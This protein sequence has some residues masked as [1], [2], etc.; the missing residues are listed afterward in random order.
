MSISL[1]DL[2]VSNGLAANVGRSIHLQVLEVAFRFFKR[3]PSALF[4]VPQSSQA[5]LHT[6]AQSQHHSWDS[7]DESCGGGG[8]GRDESILRQEG[9]VVG[10]DASMTSA[11][12]QRYRKERD[13]R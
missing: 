12:F 7:G 8:R 11:K 1:S 5:K 4:Q 6:V 3:K 10:H 9:D 2:L 13:M